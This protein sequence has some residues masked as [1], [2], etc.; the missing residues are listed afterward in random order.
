M[1]NAIQISEIIITPSPD[2]EF[3]H[4]QD[5]INRYLHFMMALLLYKL[6]QERTHEYEST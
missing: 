2:I 1:P 6:P 3:I 5:T 4:P